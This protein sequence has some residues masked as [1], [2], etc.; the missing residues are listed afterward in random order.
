MKSSLAAPS[1]NFYGINRPGC[2]PLA[3]LP[4]LRSDAGVDRRRLPALM[5]AEKML[6]PATAARRARIVHPVPEQPS[7]GRSNDAQGTGTQWLWRYGHTRK[8]CKNSRHPE[9]PQKIIS[10]RHLGDVAGRRR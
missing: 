6:P 2:R 7:P 8:S 9:V 1:D 10:F 3:E 5:Q 4:P